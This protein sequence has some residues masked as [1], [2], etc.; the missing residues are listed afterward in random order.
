[1]KAAVTRATF[2]VLVGFQLD[3]RQLSYNATR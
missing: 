3:E 1:V 2:E